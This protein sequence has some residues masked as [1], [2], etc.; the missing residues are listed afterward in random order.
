LAIHLHLSEKNMVNPRVLQLIGNLNPAGA[1]N[2]VVNL[3]NGLKTVGFDVLVLSRE[4]GSLLQ[5][6]D[7]VI[8]QRK[9]QLI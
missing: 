6:L 4:G 3:A 1:E 7:G 9:K 5:K 8:F 2:V